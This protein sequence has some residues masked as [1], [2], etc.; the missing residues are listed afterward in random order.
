MTRNCR[1]MM[2][3]TADSLLCPLHT[4]QFS[5]ES[6]D[7]NSEIISSNCVAWLH[8]NYIEP[9]WVELISIS[10]PSFH[11]DENWNSNLIAY[12][13]QCSNLYVAN[14][15]VQH[16]ITAIEDYW[17]FCKIFLIYIFLL[18]YIGIIHKWWQSVRT[19]IITTR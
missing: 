12:L 3:K 11:N 14:W 7:A 16:P 2:G 13:V 9:A 1:K 5:P 19:K 18:E 10:H 6:K 4:I 17:I 8:T 15:Q